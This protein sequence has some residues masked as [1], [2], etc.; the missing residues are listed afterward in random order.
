MTKVMKLQK[1]YF[2]IRKKYRARQAKYQDKQSIGITKEAGTRLSAR[3]MQKSGLRRRSPVAFDRRRVNKRIS[4]VK[5]RLRVALVGK[6]LDDSGA[7]RIHEGDFL[8]TALALNVNVP[9][10]RTGL[11]CRLD[12]V[13]KSPLSEIFFN[14][15][16]CVELCI[17][18][19]CP[20][21]LR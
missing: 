21:P 11:N 19:W 14:H 6:L 7:L 17:R 4:V 16:Y 10:K 15:R 3:H 1:R 18:I 8:I 5:I 20:Y 13:Q 12:V 9:W 2:H